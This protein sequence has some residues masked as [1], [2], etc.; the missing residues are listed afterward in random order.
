MA[1]TRSDTNSHHEQAESPLAEAYRRVVEIHYALAEAGRV[2]ESLHH[3]CLDQ[4]NDLLTFLDKA[5]PA[6]PLR[7]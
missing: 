1:T 3:W 2:D 7:R 5:E 4:L 6:P